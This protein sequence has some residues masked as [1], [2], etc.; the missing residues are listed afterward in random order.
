MRS[1]QHIGEMKSCYGCG[2]CT[3]ACPKKCIRMVESRDGFYIPRVDQ[4]LC[5]N[6]GLCST[7]CPKVNRPSACAKAS[8]GVHKFAAWNKDEKLRLASSS[9]GV[10]MAVAQELS[11]RGYLLCGVRYV[12]SHVRAEHF[13]ARSID[14]F[15]P[16]MGSKYIQSFTE[17][18]FTK[19]E[20]GKK[21][22]VV[23]T[24][25]QIYALRT[26]IRKQGRED[27][28][29]LMD[30]FCHGVPSAHLWRSFLRA[31]SKGR[32]LERITAMWRDK[33]RFGWEDS[34]CTMLKE[35][36]EVLYSGSRREGCGFCQHFLRSD[37][38]NIECYQCPF[39]DYSGSADLRCG[40][41]WGNQYSDR[42]KGV[43]LV[44]ALTERGNELWTKIRE[45]CVSEE[46]PLS[47]LIVAHN[48][49][50]QRFGR[51]VFLVL[52]K[53]GLGFGVAHA[54]RRMLDVM[55]RAA[56]IARLYHD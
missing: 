43:S 39:N 45:G 13:L 37:A 52:L 56:K 30:F 20:R 14:E 55:L 48:Y 50:W 17:P 2:V 49:R 8:D 7:I 26:W 54:F 11:R 22:F 16:A 34:Y 36:D 18:A 12:P 42:S 21:Y 32:P 35:S 19:F 28:F 46:L 51:S 3:A 27:D 25:C 1:L 40:D 9:G 47:D 31:H 33:A 4:G 23:G 29:F 15:L 38:Q 5:V 6:C 44:Y 10:V 41:Y 53:S 24:P